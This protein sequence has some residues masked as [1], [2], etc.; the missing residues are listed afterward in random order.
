M[1]KI[2]ALTL[3]LTLTTLTACGGGG[4][5]SSGTV[6][7]GTLTQKGSV[8]HSEKTAN[9]VNAKHS[10]GERIGDVKVCIL[11]ECSITD[12]NGQWGVNVN[13]FTG[14]DLPITLDGH[15]IN[16]STKISLPASAK[17]VSVDLGRNANNITVEKLMIDGEDHT[18]HDHS[19][20]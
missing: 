6:I 1:K 14:G 17:D 20:E 18:G 8:V 10:D 12:D 9:I 16:A 11:N 19:H 7:E 3:L 4:S 13:D 2:L 5:G 15:G